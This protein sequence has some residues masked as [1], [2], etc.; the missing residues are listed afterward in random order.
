MAPFSKATRICYLRQDP[1]STKQSTIDQ[2]R[3]SNFATLKKL[4]CASFLLDEN[5]FSTK[6]FTPTQSSLA[7]SPKYHKPR[8]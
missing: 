3:G 1:S 7:A 5:H 6:D 2:E 4:A 8:D